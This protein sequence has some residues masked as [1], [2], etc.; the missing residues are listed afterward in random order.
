M[1]PSTCTAISYASTA[2]N[3]TIPAT[4]RFA[5]YAHGPRLRPGSPA[6]TESEPV[7]GS[8]GRAPRGRL[9]LRLLPSIE[10]FV[11]L[12]PILFLIG[13]MNGV[14][15]LLGD[16][17]TGWHIRAGEWMLAHGRAPRQDIFSF[18]KPDQP[19][20]AWE[21]LSDVLMARLHL[22]G[23][24]PAVLLG[25]ICLICLTSTL[26]YRLIHRQSGSVLI[27]FVLTALAAAASSIH[28][29]AR[30]HLFTMLFMVIFYTILEEKRMRLLFILPVA[31]VI[32]TNLHGGFLA[33]ILLT[34]AYAGGY[35]ITALVARQ[36]D[37]RRAAARRSWWYGLTALGCI[38]ASLINPYSWRLH[39]HLFRFLTKPAYFRNIAEFVSISFR[40]PLAPFF[41][42]MLLLGIAT[43]FWSVLR[44]RFVPF[45]L[46]SGFAHLALLSIRNIPLFVIV[47]APPIGLALAEWLEL[48]QEQTAGSAL[49]RVL[50][51]LDSVTRRLNAA[52]AGAHY[53]IVGPAA[54]LVLGALMYARAPSPLFQSD[55]DAQ[56]YPAAALAVLRAPDRVFAN[57]TWGGYLIYR[58]YPAKVFVD[59]RSD[60]YGPAFEVEC[61]QVLSA[62]YNWDAILV[63]HAVDTVLLAVDAPLSSALK[64]SANWRPVY[65]DG[66]A[67]IFRATVPSAPIVLPKTAPAV[68]DHQVV[69]PGRD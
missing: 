14:R 24:M 69:A 49:H 21:W 54:I 62:R 47:A 17:D 39:A 35:S 1:R 22:A 7:P 48:L 53:P 29:L 43:A 9:L 34:C 27:A 32:W 4:L 52:A 16:G 13:R 46:L 64:G 40:H 41:E 68:D 56:R 23:G 33:G 65:D 19:W 31:T 26:L 51:G 36:T 2:L 6:L 3:A 55:Y 25:S 5:T 28:W 59:G 37:E 50:Q 58:R 20:Y 12:F 63:A 8:S 10:D 38:A 42:V 30:P 18:T 60:F 61:D 66:V 44:R 11:W 45:L 67:I 57:D 15:T